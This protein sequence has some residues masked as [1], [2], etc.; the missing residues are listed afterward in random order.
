MPAVQS[1]KTV[2]IRVCR[3]A[4]AES[5]GEV[6]PGATEFLDTDAGVGS[7][8]LQ[9]GAD[10]CSSFLWALP[11]VPHLVLFVI[12][13]VLIVLRHGPGMHPQLPQFV[14][15]L[16]LVLEVIQQDHRAAAAKIP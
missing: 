12:I 16:L 3:P 6:R 7:R 14:L 9:F 10:L 2:R 4:E 15:A 1:K 13:L 8:D 5:P 11:Y